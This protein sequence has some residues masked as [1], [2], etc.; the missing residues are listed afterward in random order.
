VEDNA[1]FAAGAEAMLEKLPFVERYAWYPIQWM[2][3]D[4]AYSKAGLYDPET[5][6]FTP[7]GIAYRGD[8]KH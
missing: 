4:K 3:K 5:Q 1:A 8:A 7:V 6:T 2:P